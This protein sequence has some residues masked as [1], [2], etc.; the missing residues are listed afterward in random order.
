[1]TIIDFGLLLLVA[2]I[3][4]AL[5]QG[6]AGYSAGGCLMSTLIGFIGAVIGTWL[7]GMLNLPELLTVRI[8]STPFPVLWSVLGA[9]LFVALLSLLRHP[10]RI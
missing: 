5:G 3:I 10:R 6:L 1:M 4:G 9:A 8:G 2:A 7:A